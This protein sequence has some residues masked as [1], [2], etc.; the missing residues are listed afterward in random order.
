MKMDNSKTTNGFD[1]A[2]IDVFAMWIKG[3]RRARSILTALPAVGN[4]GNRLAFDDN[5]TV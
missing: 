2:A 1:L 3:L 4:Q 5:R